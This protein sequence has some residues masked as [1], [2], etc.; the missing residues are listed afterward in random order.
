M[1]FMS[2]RRFLNTS[3]LSAEKTKGQVWFLNNV[4]DPVKMQNRTPVADI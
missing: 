3:Q 1:K 4:F 2:R